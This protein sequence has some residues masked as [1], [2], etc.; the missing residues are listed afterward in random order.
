MFLYFTV[1]KLQ[2]VYHTVPLGLSDLRNYHKIKQTYLLRNSEETKF[3]PQIGVESSRVTLSPRAFRRI[4]LT[5]TC[6]DLTESHYIWVFTVRSLKE[7]SCACSFTNSSSFTHKKK[8]KSSWKSTIFGQQS[9]RNSEILQ[10]LAIEK[11]G[12]TYVCVVYSYITCCLIANIW[13]DPD[14]FLDTIPHWWY[15][16]SIYTIK[17]L[18]IG[19]FSLTD[20]LQLFC[21]LTRY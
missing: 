18:S 8:A 21:D 14:G 9:Q 11:T 1:S 16:Q 4:S 15:H 12:K 7:G 20:Y 6:V 10:E 2:C 13:A 19:L 17:A 5:F 3:L